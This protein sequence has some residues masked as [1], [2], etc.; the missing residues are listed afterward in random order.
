MGKELRQYPRLERE[1]SVKYEVTGIELPR[2]LIQ[3]KS[4]GWAKNIS[5]G[6]M[7]LNVYGVRKSKLKQLLDRSAK[8]SLGFYLPDFQN[9]IKTFGEVRWY[10]C[11]SPWWKIWSKNWSLGI[12]FIYIQPEDRD[13]IIKYVINTQIEEHLIKHQ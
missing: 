5:G 13:C 4:K 2:P 3:P 1:F 7:Y 8:F 6:G 12:K 11:I 10:K 9:K